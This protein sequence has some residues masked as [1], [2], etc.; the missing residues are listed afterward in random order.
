LIK[1]KFQQDVEAAASGDLDH[2]LEDAQGKLAFILLCD[3]FTRNIYR[4]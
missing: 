3:Q 1:E 4:K 2:W